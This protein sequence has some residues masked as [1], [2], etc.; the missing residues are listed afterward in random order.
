VTKKLHYKIFIIEDDHKL[1]TL[2]K[3]YTIKYDFTID[4]VKDFDNILEK[5]NSIKS[6]IILLEI[7]L[8]SFDGFYWC[9][10]IRGISL[11]PI[12]IISARNSSMAGVI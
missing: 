6:D 3:N 10:K 8:L 9:R 7:N 11:V 1:S 4:L 2:L 12:I 5:F